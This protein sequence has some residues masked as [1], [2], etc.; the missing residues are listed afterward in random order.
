MQTERRFS[1]TRIFR[2]VLLLCLSLST[3]TLAHSEGWNICGGANPQL[4]VLPTQG[5]P[6]NAGTLVTYTISVTDQDN[7]AC[8]Y[9]ELAL[10]AQ[11]DNSWNAAPTMTLGVPGFILAPGGSGST[12]L[13]VTSSSSESSGSHGIIV[14]VTNYYAPTFTTSATAYYNISGSS[15][16]FTMQ[17]S[18]A[19]V[20]VSPGGTGSTTLSC[21]TPPGS[22]SVSLSVTGLP[23]DNSI[24][25][26][27]SPSLPATSACPGTYTLTFNATSSASGSYPVTVTASGT[28][29][30]QS[31]GVTV[32]VTT[33]PSKTL[34]A[35]TVTP[36]DPSV[37]VNGTEPFTATGTY[38]D[39]STKDFTATAAW[40]SDTPSVATITNP[41]G[42]ATGIDGGCALITATDTPS[43]VSGS[44]IL[45][46]ISSQPLASYSVFSTSNPPVPAGSN[47]PVGPPLE[48]GMAFM[49]DRN[50][51]IGALRFYNP[52]GA[53]H[54]G[55]LWSSTGTLLASAMFSAGSVG[56]ES[57][58]LTSA[59]PITANTV[60]VVSYQVTGPYYLNQN[61]FNVPVGSSPLYAVQNSS[62]SSNGV[63]QYD[64]GST[65]VFPNFSASGTNF[66]VDV[67]FTPATATACLTSLAVTPASASINVP[68][69]QQ[70]T[71]TGT[72]SDGSTGPA[73]GVAW[74]SSNTTV[75]TIT[76]SGG[77]ATGIQA[78]SSPVTITATA[79]HGVSGTASLTVGGGQN[80]FCL[81][82]SSGCT[83]T[84]AVPA[85]NGNAGGSIE[86]GMK[87]TSDEA[88]TI[89]ALRFYK[90]PLD[91]ST[92]HV[93][94]L[95][96]STGTSLASVTFTGETASGWQQATLTPPVAI[97]ANTVYVVSYHTPGSFSAT[98]GEFNEPV[99]NSPLHAVVNSSGNGNGVWVYSTNSTFPGYSGSGAN[100]WVDVVFTPSG[101]GATLKS[102][103]VTPTNPSI[104]LY[105]EQQFKATGTY[106][107]SSQQDLTGSAS[108]F[109]G[110]ASVATITSP[111]GLATGVGLG[112]SVITASQ[113]G[114]SGTTTLTVTNTGAYSLFNSSP[115]C[116][117]NCSVPAELNQNF[118]SS[119]ELG[120][121]FTSDQAGQI[122]AIRF[123]KSPSDTSTQHAVNLWSSTGTLLGSATSANE[124]ASGWQQVNLT[125]PVAITASTMYVV[126]YHTSGFYSATWGYFNGSVDNPPLHA[127][128]NSVSSNGV[129][130]LSASST[131]PEY[132]G[133]GANYWV[134]V[135]FQ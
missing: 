92:Q 55:N 99:D 123:Y 4:T 40:S 6:V 71:A 18:P 111:G 39:S 82:M 81:F 64:N 117:S 118:G 77:L 8:D 53:Q 85:V 51:S 95:W 56:W 132:S 24:T 79:A 67:V 25:G 35:I 10:T 101:G 65:S 127:V 49:A 33:T 131:F 109:S 135:V 29:V 48:L 129:W 89:N 2:A 34:T 98:W 63:W 96:S 100:Y 102:I 9:A 60:Y 42:V 69:T 134:D 93:G 76:S 3:A 30:T 84:L 119:M 31:A 115:Q 88:G 104:N 23:S 37:N 125:S 130:G 21:T 22:V 87:F 28:G 94:T 133:A 38:S 59:V 13:Q 61:Y 108:W 45:T 52:D 54:K 66:W 20:T 103:A 43:G 73:T 110:T 36:A 78:S 17:A 121:K 14:T 97:T 19:T 124:T 116:K 75:A 27:F 58:T 44:T 105:A 90:S 15:P 106:S 1:W 47:G 107:D 74:S 62:T 41:G 72:Y 68:A 12:T 122:T 7:P 50:G 80:Q 120:M 57:V 16:T 32:N 126:S 113:N 26:S 83:V 46:V 128:S 5:A 112:A 86:L 11:P 91:S 70:F 114:I